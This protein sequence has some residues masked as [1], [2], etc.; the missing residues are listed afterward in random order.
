MSASVLFGALGLAFDLGR[1]FIVQTEL[2]YYVDAAALAAVYQLDGTRSGVQKANTVATAGPFG[3]RNPAGYDFD[4]QPVTGV[5]TSYATSLNGTYDNYATAAA[6]ATNHYAFIKLTVNAAVPISFLRII[7]GIPS[8]MNALATAT[9]GQMAGS[10]ISSGGS[11]PFMPDAH[12]AS[13]TVNFGLTPGGEYTLKWG[14]ASSNGNGNGKGKGNGN[15]NTSADTTCTGDIG[16]DNPNPTAQHGFIDIGEGNSNANVRTSIAFGGYPNAD[17]TPSSISVGTHLSGVPGNRGSSIFDALQER[18][19]QDT[20]HT[21]TTYAQYLANSQG[22]GRRVLTV[23]IGDPNTWSGNGNGSAAVVG[24]ANFFL[25][26]TYSGS[27][28]PICAIYIGP[29]SLN[30][31]SSARTDST[32][33]YTNVLFR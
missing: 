16:W 9:A 15:G 18:V 23:P 21:S 2:Q 17:S 28:G 10:T 25:E 27:S 32:K 5:Q 33:V 19:N 1:R 14:N 22:N 26:T 12:D 31:A 8:T 20:D 6:P 30:G 29:A 11:G 24:F 13:D 7:R 4:S 3:M